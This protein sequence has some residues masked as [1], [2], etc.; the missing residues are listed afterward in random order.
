MRMD[1]PKA[2]I[3]IHCCLGLK[4]LSLGKPNLIANCLEN[5]FSPHDMCEGNHERLVVA[6]IHALFEVMD[7]TPLEK[8]RL[9][10]VLINS[11]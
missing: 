9:C 11:N 5:Q 10:D 1:N 6:H 2:P 8:I 4:F 7:N 3:A